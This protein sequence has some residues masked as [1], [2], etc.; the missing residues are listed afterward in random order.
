MAINS[1]FIKAS[2]PETKKSGTL[3]PT[4]IHRRTRALKYVPEGSSSSRAG[5]SNSEFFSRPRFA[6]RRSASA[7]TGKRFSSLL[8]LARLP[9]VP[10]ARLSRRSDDLGRHLSPRLGDAGNQGRGRPPHSARSL[11]VANRQLRR[12]ASRE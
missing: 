3:S 10:P 9:H 1:A 7:Q 4:P 2:S 11:D 8:R 12:P 6:F 5:T